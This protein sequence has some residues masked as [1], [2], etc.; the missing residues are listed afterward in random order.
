MDSLGHS[1]FP[2]TAL[3][4]QDDEE[5]TSGE[6]SLQITS[7][8]LLNKIV[9]FEKESAKRILADKLYAKICAKVVQKCLSDEQKQCRKDEC[10]GMLERITNEPNL[11]VSSLNL[12]QK[13]LSLRGSGKNGE[14]SQGH[15][16]TFVSGLLP[17]TAAPRIE[18][19]EC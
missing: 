10:V 8:N 15:S 6:R 17:A 7:L 12:A 9:I 13:V 18:V 14:S 3:G 11:L 4:R 2:P 5:A 16:K 1:S 19:C